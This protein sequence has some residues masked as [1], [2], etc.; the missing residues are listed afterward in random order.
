MKDGYPIQWTVPEEGIGYEGNY[1][2][3]LKGTKKLDL[4]KKIIDYLGSK[5]CS[6]FIGSLGYFPPRPGIASALYGME[7]PKFINVDHAWA[8]KNKRKVVKMWK[9]GLEVCS[10]PFSAIFHPG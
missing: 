3:I 6:E 7:K 2:T 4:C 1:C 8:V 9:R 5:D 10:T